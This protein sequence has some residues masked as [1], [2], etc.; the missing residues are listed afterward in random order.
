M[1]DFIVSDSVLL[2]YK[3]TEESVEIT[4]GIKAI[5]QNAFKDNKHIK[6]V[7]I[8][9]SVSELG[10]NA[11]ENCTNLESVIFEGD[12]IR[13]P[14]CCFK[15]C[16]SLKSVILPSLLRRVGDM[17]FSECKALKEIQ[18]PDSITK[19]D[20]NAFSFSGLKRVKL[21]ESLT[22]IH[23]GAFSFCD[24]LS[25]IKL[26][27]GSDWENRN[28]R[29]WSWAFDRELLPIIALDN[30]SRNSTL[31]REIVREPTI[32]TESLIKR[33]R[34]DLLDKLLDYAGK[35]ITPT[36]LDFMLKRAQDLNSNEATKILLEYKN[37]LK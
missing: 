6:S 21:P 30:L 2:E 19:I 27:S 20:F 11:F 22:T 10:E 1:N 4:D 35:R 7:K 5:A 8:G 37:N 3:G 18:L 12:I 25:Y 31:A 13:L 24:N 15:G 36:E 26:G 28:I 16:E 34:I 23:T 29:K 33:G 32:A 9:E 17:C 14:W